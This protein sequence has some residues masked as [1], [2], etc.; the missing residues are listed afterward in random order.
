MD[1]KISFFVLNTTGSPVK[2]LT[3]S[4]A[5]LK[6]LSL[7]LMFALI[8]SGYV[9][10][11][12]YTLKIMLPSSTQV[13]SKIDNQE[14][15][16]VSQRQQIQNFAH[17]INTLKTKL[18]DLNRF[19]KK[20]R[21]IANIEKSSSQD[22]LFGVGGS[23]PEDLNPNIELESKHNRLV[24]DIHEQVEQLNVASVNQKDGFESLLKYLEDQRNIL[25]STPAI[26]PVDGWI[27]SRFGYRT[28]P[29]TGRR[30]FHKGL[31][32]A[33]RKK[34]PISATANGVVVFVGLKGMLGKV[35]V[36]DHGHGIST[37]YGHV[38]KALKKTGE[39]VT[40]GEE[41]ALV[42]NSGRT[43]GS[44]VHYEVFLNGL[45]VN[46]EKYIID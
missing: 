26:S 46:P 12:Y 18:I 29:F 27:T 37:R 2:Q 21:I 20:I 34:S 42:G 19:E 14:D 17:E 32:I 8:V 9:V 6:V 23:V 13:K 1:K 36:L 7:L 4:K 16:I 24:Q 25:A 3:V 45:P 10:Y 39:K 40:R 31:D 43:T 33:T 22:G 44:H 28:S 5:L 35:V 41:I 15:E 30:E 11:D 38:D